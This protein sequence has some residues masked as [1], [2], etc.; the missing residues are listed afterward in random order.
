MKNTLKKFISCILIAVLIVSAFI[1]AL[2]P[3]SMKAAAVNVYTDRNSKEVNG[4]KFTDNSKLAQKLDEA[5][6]GNIGL[7]TV[8][9]KGVKNY[10]KCIIGS[11]AVARSY[12][13]S[14]IDARNYKSKYRCKTCLSYANA[15]YNFLFGD[16]PENL[17]NKSLYSIKQNWPQGAASYKEFCKNEIGLGTYINVAYSRNRHALILLKYDQDNLWYVDGNGEE[18]SEPYKQKKATGGAGTGGLIAIRKTTWNEFNKYFHSS[19]TYVVKPTSAAFEKL[20]DTIIPLKEVPV[21]MKLQTIKDKVAARTAPYENASKIKSV[22]NKGEIPINTTI[23]IVASYINTYN[24]LWYKAKEGYW[25]YGQ[26]LGEL[27]VATVK[28][29]VTKSANKKKTSKKVNTPKATVVKIDQEYVVTGPIP[30]REGYKFLGW[31]TKENATDGK[32]YQIGDKIP[33]KGPCTLYPVW[34]KTKTSMTIDEYT[35]NLDA[36]QCSLVNVVC[37]GDLKDV[38]QEITCKSDNESVATAGIQG[39]P[40]Y[41][42]Y[43]LWDKLE[44]TI[45][46]NAHNPGSA[47]IEIS[48]SNKSGTLLI[49]KSILVKV[50]AS[51]NINYYDD[52]N[53]NI[54]KQQTKKYNKSIDLLDYVPEKQG[55]TFLGWTSVA[56]SS[57]VEYGPGDFYEGNK[58]LNLYP[59]WKEKYEINY[60]YD[61]GLLRI[62][63]LGD[64]ASY[65]T[66]KAPWA[67]Y[68]SDVTEIQIEA[69]VSSIGSNA[70]ANFKKL[71]KVTICYGV[72]AIG[73]KAF[74][75][76]TA[77]TEIRIP[78]TVTKINARAFSGCTA[79]KSAIMNGT[80]RTRAQAGEITIGAFVFENCVSLATVDVPDTVTEIGEGAFTGCTAMTEFDIPA[81]V[82]TISDAAFFGCSALESIDIPSG[83]TEIGD[84]AFTGCSAAETITIPST[85]YS[86]GDQAFSGCSVITAVALPDNIDIIGSGVFT[87]C[88][89]LVSVNIPEGIEHIGDGMFNG[90]SALESVEIPESVSDIGDGAF[91]YC[92]SLTDINIPSRVNEISDS[93]FYGCSSL[94]EFDIPESIV[95]IGDYAFGGCNNLQNVNISEGTQT[96]GV[97][98]FENCSSLKS[99][100]TPTSLTLI[101][102]GAFMGCSAIESFELYESELTIGKEAFLGCSSLNDLQLPED[103]VS[104][105]ENAF[106]GCTAKIACFSTSSVYDQMLD[107]YSNTD[108][109]IPVSGITVNTEKADM[110]VGQSLNLTA[111]VSPSNAT[112]KDIIWSSSN[113][114]TITVDESGKITAISGGKATVTATTKDNAFVASCEITSIVPVKGISLAYN[115]ATTYVDD[116]FSMYYTLAPESPT[117]IDVKWTSSDEKIATVDE[118]GCVSILSPGKVTITATSVDG[119]FSD[120]CVLECENYVSATGIIIDKTLDLKVG[121]TKQLH[122]QLVP[123]DTTVKDIYWKADESGVIEITSDGLITAL[124]EGTATIN[125]YWG[126]DELFASCTVTV[127]LPTIDVM[128]QIRTPSTTTIKYGDAIILHADISGAIPNDAKIVW[129]ASNN[130]FDMTVSANGQTCQITPKASGTTVFTVKIVESDGTFISSDT[131]EM[132]SKAGFF[133]KII[134]FFKKLFG[135]NKIIPYALKNMIE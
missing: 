13:N 126:A 23:E 17:G 102:D 123:A 51:Y 31:S 86:I 3:L 8:G 37:D 69:G 53:G 12:S 70:F 1:P 62:Y 50:D 83:I 96:I 91:G 67:N 47:N 111:N 112:C 115:E 134:A 5:F 74:L 24:N 35:V 55:F 20:Y 36:S 119:G 30:E 105:G 56:G 63:G 80:Q 19:I 114:E 65:P 110:I 117:N 88:S 16:I 78:I 73:A 84:G 27:P 85:V 75:N 93:M 66:G 98:A 48:L 25:I 127:T 64:M 26:R 4:A 21:N 77:L 39:S 18:V 122:A 106:G 79:L 71:T 100:T 2:S 44:N 118:S 9:E 7:Y 133:S 94:T 87:N 32:Y 57:T 49:S 97:C 128:V 92:A 42:N 90:C 81:G 89:A 14:V 22:G 6:D 131:Q 95:T 60:E 40:K 103:V 33:I 101:D 43:I 58:N 15:F 124:K 130:N 46:I 29:N 38:K 121:E 41:T 104:I 59:V 109:I 61:N 11:H 113:P 135:S 34:K 68:A 72:T 99:V 116:I 82:E 129:E 125:A 132:I 10:K 45:K 28:Y 107:T 108:S 120:S 76:C 54:A 52:T